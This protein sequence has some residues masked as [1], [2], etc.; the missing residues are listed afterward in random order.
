MEL[1]SINGVPISAIVKIHLYLHGIIVPDNLY[2]IL[3]SSQYNGYRTTS[4]VFMKIGGTLSKIEYEN[5]KSNN[6][7]KHLLADI[8]K[9]S[10]YKEYLT[11]REYVTAQLKKFS[12]FTHKEL[13]DNTF[14]MLDVDKNNKL[15]IVG[16]Y[17]VGEN[18]YKIRINDCG[19]FKQGNYMDSESVVVQAG[20]I[21]IRTS[22]CGSN[23]ISG[24]KFCDFGKGYD[25]Y[26]KNTFNNAKKVHIN[27][28]IKCL[29]LKEKISSLFITG[30]NPSLDDM[31]CW[32][33]LVK[34]SINTFKE[35]LHS[36]GIENG[37]VDIM[38]TPRGFDRYVYD[39]KVRYQEYKK[40]LE[41]LKSI[42]ITTVAPNME[43]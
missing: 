22:I 38:M 11:I 8:S 31:L 26:I 33:D 15:Y 29:V 24:C 9:F 17:I 10:S 30:G 23:C 3:S 27:N 37:E 35:T 43:L 16:Q 12:D 4:G 28:L 20:G 42:G 41:Y 2:E 34:E 18:K 36:T 39:K 13:E 25:N 5:M 40:Y 1:N 6:N 21:R 32:T 14:F 19:F 7:G